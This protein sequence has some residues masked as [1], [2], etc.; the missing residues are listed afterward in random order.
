M[1]LI[2]LFIFAIIGVLHAGVINAIVPCDPFAFVCVCLV[3]ALWYF[4]PMF[5]A[6][7]KEKSNGRTGVEEG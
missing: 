1:F 5:F 6:L 4:R 3:S 7:Q 2:G